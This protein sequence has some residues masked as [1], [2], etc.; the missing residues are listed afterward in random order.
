[1]Q[2]CPWAEGQPALYCPERIGAGKPSFKHPHPVRQR[3]I[4]AEER[5]G[6][7]GRS[8]R[9]RTK[10]AASKGGVISIGGELMHRQIEGLLCQPC[11]EISMR[12][13]PKLVDLAGREGLKPYKIGPYKIAYTTMTRDGMEKQCGRGA[14][15]ETAT[16]VAVIVTRLRSAKP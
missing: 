2:P 1:M 16:G 12:A 13:C 3:R 6:V 10:W 7:C 15:P 8:L 14:Y 5:C 4:I 9:N 11:S